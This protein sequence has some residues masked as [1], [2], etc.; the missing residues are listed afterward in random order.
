MTKIREVSEQQ[1]NAA[2]QSLE[3]EIKAINSISEVID[4]ELIAMIN[5][6][7]GER[8]TNLIKVLKRDKDAINELIKQKDTI[9]QGN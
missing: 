6:S 1:I 8:K 2:L 5:S 9:L 4:A 3:N 7:S